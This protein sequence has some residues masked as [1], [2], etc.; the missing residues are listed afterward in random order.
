M[1]ASILHGLL[2]LTSVEPTEGQD[3]KWQPPAE[4]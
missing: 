4:E 2:A 3:P 1:H